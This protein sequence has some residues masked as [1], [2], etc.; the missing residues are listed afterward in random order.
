MQPI[1]AIFFCMIA[2][3]FTAINPVESVELNHANENV[4]VIF[5]VNGVLTQNSGATKILGYKKFI[6]Y[7]LLH[8]HNPF[9]IKAAIKQKLFN[10]LHSIKPRDPQEVDCQDEA[11]NIL[12][13]I[14][15]DWMKGTMSS[16]QLLKAVD[17]AE[18]HNKKSLE[19]AIVVAIAKMMFTP[20]L[21]MQSQSW[22]PETIAFAK[23]LKKQGYKLYIFSNWDAESFAL[24]K[25]KYP[26]TIGLFDGVVI[27]GDINLIKP[28]IN[29]YRQALA[30]CNIDINRSI[31]FDDQEVNVK[32]AQ[33][34]GLASIQCK[35]IG[36]SARPDIASLEK[37]FKAWRNTHIKNFTVNDPLIA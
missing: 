23:K 28:D 31:F 21:F 30:Q 19:L 6:A 7:L 34:I 2:Y 32:A 26:N 13:Q 35:S 18:A 5:D 33:S 29:F 12:P 14:M 8:H 1:T 15:C 17:N 27:S 24:M 20:E 3:I 16:A 37:Q 25:D 4:H 9:T 36:F 10:F 22:V 11:G